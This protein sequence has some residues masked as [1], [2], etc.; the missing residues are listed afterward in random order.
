MKKETIKPA[1]KIRHH[2]KDL[3]EGISMQAFT[4]ALFIV[5]I[6]AEEFRVGDQEGIFRK[7]E[8]EIT[9][10]IK[11]GTIHFIIENKI[12]LKIT[13]ELF[14][15]TVKIFDALY[16]S[17]VGAIEYFICEKAG[18][19]SLLLMKNCEAMIVIAPRVEED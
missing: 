19:N 14:D 15:K 3:K 2:I 12:V 17:E 6:D 11:K 8:G 1:K 9:R 13:G 4:M 5:P 18:R 7:F 10:E 16:D